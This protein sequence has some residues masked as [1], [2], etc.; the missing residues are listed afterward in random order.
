MNDLKENLTTLGEWR[1]NMKQVLE[2]LD[3]LEKQLCHS[4]QAA[5]QEIRQQFLQL[6]QDLV[7]ALRQRTATLV[8]EVVAARTRCLGPLQ[9]ARRQVQKEISVADTVYAEGTRLLCSQNGEQDSHTREQARQFCSKV[10]DF[11]SLPEIPTPSEVGCI[12]VSFDA[13]LV[14]RLSTGI[15]HYGSVS[16][17]CPVLVTHAE[18]LPGALR[19]HWIEPE[20]DTV[21]EQQEYCLQHAAGNVLEDKV[22]EWQFAEVYR[23]MECSTV[24]RGLS[25]GRP[26]SFRVAK[27]SSGAKTWSSWSPAFVCLT[28]IPHYEWDPQNRSYELTDEKRIATR[29][30]VAGSDPFLFSKES[31]LRLNHSLVFKFLDTP[32]VWDED[33][34]LALV[35][36]TP[37][38]L[39]EPGVIFVNMEGEI[40]VDGRQTMTQLPALGKG[41]ELTL[42][43][44]PVSDQKV[45]VAVASYQKQATYDFRIPPTEGPRLDLRFAASFKGEGWKILLE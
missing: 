23:G 26:Q 20:E 24:V 12:S 4:G 18:Q 8:S 16:T 40:F 39:L 41:L 43:L 5:E 11:E 42:E 9:R 6:E 32:D 35:A 44:D 34:G 15:L 22:E 45:R 2:E 31:L 38:T 21:V 27:R 30:R 14:A 17:G 13:S 29:T 1:D 28:T 25:L 3:V 36:G 10:S 19:I 33:E 7:S 37:Q